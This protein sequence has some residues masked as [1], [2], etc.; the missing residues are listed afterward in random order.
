MEFFFAY[1]TAFSLEENFKTMNLSLPYLM[2]LIT[3]IFVSHV[4]ILASVRLKGDGK[5]I[6]IK[7][8]N[9]NIFLHK[10]LINILT[11]FQPT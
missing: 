8:P 9:L 10:I 4:K 3:A 1:S 7:V 2:D 6:K 5:S 11:Q